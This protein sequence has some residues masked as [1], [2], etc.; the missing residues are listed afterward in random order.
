MNWLILRV[1]VARAWNSLP[2]SITALTSLPSFK[3]QLEN[4]FIYQIL[5]ISLIFLLVICVPCPRSYCSLCHVNLYVLLLLLLLLRYLVAMKNLRNVDAFGHYKLWKC[6]T[7]AMRFTTYPRVAGTWPTV[8]A[9]RHG[10]S[11]SRCFQ[12]CWRYSC[13]TLHRSECTASHSTEPEWT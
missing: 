3:R 9:H 2:T 12:L 5:P 1:T 13:R 8:S 6:E 11:P 10:N 7:Y 4:I